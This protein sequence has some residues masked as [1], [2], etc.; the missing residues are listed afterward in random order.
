MPELRGKWNLRWK[1]LDNYRGVLLL[2]MESEYLSKDLI[3]LCP[4]MV[5]HWPSTLGAFVDICF[6]GVLGACVSI[7]DI[8]RKVIDHVGH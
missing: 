3:W 7:S 8:T 4:Y 6:Q 2:E 1:L 5:T